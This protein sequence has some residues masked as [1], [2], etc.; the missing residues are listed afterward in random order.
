MPDCPICQWTPANTEYPFLWETPAW[1]VKLAPNQSLPGRCIVSTRRHV[2]DLPGLNIQEWAELHGVIRKLE[3]A[4]RASLGAEMFNWSCYLNHAYR[5]TRPEPHVHWWMVP[6]YR[7]PVTLGGLRF[8]DPYFGS[9]Y[10]H[11][12]W[13]RLP[14]QVWEDLILL[15][16]TALAAD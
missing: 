10:D 11:D 1:I 15:I 2:P 5:E 9:P 6:R 4:I 16:Q 12:R 8:E 7:E 14:E 3:S 13:Q